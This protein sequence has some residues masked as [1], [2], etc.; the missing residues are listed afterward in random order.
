MK[1]VQTLLKYIL[2][3]IFAGGLLYFSFS[4]VNL[5]TLWQSIAGAHYGWIW[6]STIPMTLAHVA[7]ARRW[8]LLLAPL[9]HRP[10][11]V[12]TTIAVMAGYFANLILPRMGEVTRCGVL[13]K[14][15]RVPIEQGVGTVLV[16]R[17]F[18]LVMLGVITGLAFLL[19][20]Q[21]LSNFFLSALHA[22]QNMTPEQASSGAPVVLWILGG[23][24]VFVLGALY[25]LWDKIVAQPFAQKILHWLTG[26]WKAVLSVRQMKSPGEFLFQTL[27]IWGG[28][29][30]TLYLS[31]ESLDATAEL[32]PLSALMILVIGSFGMVAPVQGG[33]GAY[34]WIVTAGLVQLYGLSQ[35]DGA[36]AATLFHA[37]QTLY[38][39]LVGAAC[40]LIALY[41]KPV[42][43]RAQ[44]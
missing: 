18:D 17:V 13:Q 2:P 28:Y 8:Q 41:L 1:A 39:L 19:Q 42:V 5:D 25:F 4:Q 21:E 14:S 10:S 11:L 12:R 22:K 27:V 30:L 33:L 31:Y 40:G 35:Q 38:T 29:F 44:S 24:V 16:E 7:R 20:W 9:H 34:H 3:L 6:L 43:K 26:L 36:A 32:G 15:D 37:A 23:G